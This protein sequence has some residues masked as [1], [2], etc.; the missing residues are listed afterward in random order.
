MT[1]Y[2][3]TFDKIQQDSCTVLWPEG[4]QSRK[5]LDDKVEKLMEMRKED[6]IPSAE[7]VL[8]EAKSDAKIPCAYDITVW[9]ELR[10]QVEVKKEEEGK[11][12]KTFANGYQ[13]LQTSTDETKYAALFPPHKSCNA[14]TEPVPDVTPEKTTEVTETVSTLPPRQQ[15]DPDAF[16]RMQD[17]DAIVERKVRKIL[18]NMI[19]SM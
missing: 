4:Q 12:V 14:D 2:Q 13:N 11:A 19:A 3:T 6:I 5:A 7:C 18:C 1:T 10:R 15:P 9:K 8:L 17:I 16:V